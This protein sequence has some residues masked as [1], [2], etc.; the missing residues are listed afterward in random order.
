MAR[1]ALKDTLVLHLVMLARQCLVE[2]D[3]SRMRKVHDALQERC[4]VLGASYETV[5]RELAVPRPLAAR[6]SDQRP[7]KFFDL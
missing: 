6:S 5:L 1:N 3:A 7:A 4:T 2:E